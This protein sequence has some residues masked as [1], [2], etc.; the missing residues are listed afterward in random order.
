M[1]KTGKIFNYFLSKNQDLIFF[2]WFDKSFSIQVS[3]DGVA[4][5]NFEHSWGDGVAVLRCVQDVHK[6]SIEN[7]FVH[8]NMTPYDDDINNVIR[9]GEHF[10]LHY[11][12]T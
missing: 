1:E 5:V 6:D 4:A 10:T 7:A 12:G 8:P 2:R 9:L 11:F 3:Q